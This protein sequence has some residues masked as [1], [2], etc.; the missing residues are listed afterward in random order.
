MITL[1]VIHLTHW[2]TKSCLFG[3]SVDPN[4]SMTTHKY[5]GNYPLIQSSWQMQRN[6]QHWRT[7]M[8][9]KVFY[10]ILLSLQLW[11]AK[12]VRHR[13]EDW[14][15]IFGTHMNHFRRGMVST[16]KDAF[17]FLLLKMIAKLM[18]GI[19]DTLSIQLLFVQL[20]VVFFPKH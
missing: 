5:A 20:L 16:K 1:C 3:K 12:S 14:A 19:K 18:N 13:R 4:L 10:S 2:I 6:I 15:N 9:S 11:L 7:L 17:C 8:P